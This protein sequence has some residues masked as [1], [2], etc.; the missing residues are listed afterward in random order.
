MTYS[1]VGQ[2]LLLLMI[3][4]GAPILATR[5][6]GRRLSWPVDGG[7][8]FLDG[9]P[10]FGSS[11]TMRGLL[12]SLATTALAARFVGLSAASGAV[13]AALAMAGDLLSSFLKR[14]ITLVP[15]ARAS[16]LDQIPEA[17]FPA[18]YAMAELSLSAGE[19]AVVVAT[20]L[21]GGLLLSRLLFSLGI[22]EQPY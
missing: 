7:A 2:M 8:L 22:R 4:N 6:F 3:A 21:V 16:G 9:R 1:A 17:L 19:A 11:K 5:I 13:I 14:R 12:A 18:L 15:S 10:I 20:F